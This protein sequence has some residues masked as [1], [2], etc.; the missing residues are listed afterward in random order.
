MNDL[1]RTFTRFTVRGAM[2]ILMVVACCLSQLPAQDDAAKKELEKLQGTWK[3]TSMM[4]NGEN[5]PA[6]KVGKFTITCKGDQ[7]IPAEN[8]TDVAMIKINH[9]AK[10]ATKD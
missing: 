9:T 8:P 2:S 5:A 3:A 6:D 1:T 10:P 7:F 4:F